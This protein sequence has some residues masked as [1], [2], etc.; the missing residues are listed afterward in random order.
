LNFICPETFI[1][2]GVRKP[3]LSA[4]HAGAV[5]GTISAQMGYII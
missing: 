1:R 2:P 5:A 4:N 3:P